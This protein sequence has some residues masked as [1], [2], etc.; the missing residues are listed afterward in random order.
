[1]ETITHE[2]EPF[3]DADS[4]ILILGTMPSPK[5]RERGFYYMHPQNR[6]WRVL[7]DVLGENFPETIGARKE[8]LR[9]NRIALWDVLSSCEISG[10]SDASIRNAKPNDIAWLLKQAP[11]GRIYATGKTAEKYYNRFLRKELGREIIGLPSTSPANCRLRYEDLL[12]EYRV[13]TEVL[14]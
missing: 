14:R 9:R 8:L 5:S 12:K 2:I 6:F 1:M 13:I 10:A 3:F 7:S 11:I 4:K